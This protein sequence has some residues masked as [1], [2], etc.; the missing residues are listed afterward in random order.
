MNI[1]S[2]I[3]SLG[4]L[5]SPAL[6]VG[7]GGGSS[8]PVVETSDVPVVLTP[9]VKVRTYSLEQ[10]DNI[11]FVFDEA[12]QQDMLDKAHVTAIDSIELR[13]SFNG[14]KSTGLTLTHSASDPGVWFIVRSLASVNVPGNSGQPEFKFVVTGTVNGTAAT[15][16]WLDVSPTVPAGYSFSGNHIVVFQGDNVD[17]IVANKT[18]AETLKTLADFDLGTVQG[19]ADL[20]NFRQAPGASKLFRSYH[21][22]KKSRPAME[23]EAPRI[24]LVNQLMEENGV[25]SVITLSALE[26]ADVGETI[27]PYMQGIMDNDQNLV[28]DVGYNLVYFQS[29]TADFGNLIKGVVTFIVNPATEVPVMVHCRLGTDRT[30]VVTAT[31]AALTGSSWEAIAADYQKSNAMGMQEFRDFKILQYSFEHMLQIPRGSIGGVNLQQK[32]REYFINNG[33]LTQEQIDL[34][35]AKIV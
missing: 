30:G 24:A 29:D 4:L 25:K 6:L 35:A 27:T 16:A 7:C 5:L 33:Y 18:I 21:P 28:L 15:T 17:T 14:W 11:V 23:T 26:T 2:I 22:F 20:S 8:D 12:S 19:K 10:A 3:L 1:K 31:L 13:G 9:D 34:L 32:M